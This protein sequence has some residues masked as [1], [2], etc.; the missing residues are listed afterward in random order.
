MNARRWRMGRRVL[1]PFPHTNTSR[2]WFMRVSGA[3]DFFSDALAPTLVHA[4][5]RFFVYI[6]N[7]T[8]RSSW[9]VEWIEKYFPLN[10]LNSFPFGS[11]KYDFLNGNARKR[12]IGTKHFPFLCAFSKFLFNST[13]VKLRKSIKMRN[14]FFFNL[15]LYRDE[16][17]FSRIREKKFQSS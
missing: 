5:V 17:S 8:Y 12:P 11:E 14:D 16:K 9:L 6:Q 13:C 3:A 4:F 1:L 7:S 2:N 15:F 10:F